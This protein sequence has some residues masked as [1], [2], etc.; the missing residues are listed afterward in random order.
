LKNGLLDFCPLPSAL[1]ALPSALFKKLNLMNYLAHLYLSFDDEE[2]LVRNFK[3][4]LFAIQTF[5]Q[6]RCS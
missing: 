2:I 3:K 1:C 4:T 5:V 6:N